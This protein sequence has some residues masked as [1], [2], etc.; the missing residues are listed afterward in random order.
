MAEAGREVSA[1]PVEQ[2]LV[3]GN[4]TSLERVAPRTY[5]Q[6]SWQRFKRNRLAVGSG[7][8]VI[9]IFCF[10]FGAPLVSRYVTHVS[11]AD[12]ALLA[13]FEQP[14]TP[15]HLLG[16]D[17]LGRDVLTRLAYGTRVSMEVAL[18]A[19]GS[20]LTIGVTLGAIAGFYGRWIDTVIMRFVDI[21]LSI[22]ALF[23][24][25]FVGAL[26][27]ISATTLALVISAVSW[28]GLS[29]LVRGEI[30]ALKRRDYV[31]AARVVGASDAR[32]IAR[33]MVPNVLP[34]V[35]VW[36]TLAVPI[37]IIVEASLSF[38]GLGVQPP[39]PSLGNM[40]NGAINFMDQAWTLVFIPGFMIYI[41]VLAINLLGNGLRDALDPRLGQ[42]N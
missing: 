35:I 21:M 28:M 7:V 36:A 15:G 17:N 13:R 30:M 26:F 34:I 14:G 4:L 31:E 19:V 23:L 12:Q 25:I 29:R 33:H 18:L 27:T 9:I 1:Q 6:Q 32:I 20:A 8:L 16:T 37:F 5:L 2:P 41:M 3:T 40:L 10:G 38:L 11:Y 22:P 39:V 42:A 24:L